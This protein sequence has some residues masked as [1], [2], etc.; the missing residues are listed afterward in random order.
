MKLETAK[1]L[2]TLLGDKIYEAEQNH[3]DEI[4]ISGASFSEMDSDIDRFEKAI[5][6]K[7]SQ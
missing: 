7:E 2:H 3:N 1:K 5:R 4:D 6:E